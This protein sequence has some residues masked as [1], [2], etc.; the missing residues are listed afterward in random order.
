MP[1]YTGRTRAKPRRPNRRRRPSR[2]R[3]P[4]WFARNGRRL[5]WAITLFTIAALGYACWALTWPELTIRTIEVEGAHR[6]SRSEICQASGVSVGE[7]L[8]AVSTRRVR[9]LV[10]ELPQVESA[11][12][13]RRLPGTLC[14]H[15]SERMPRLVLID[16]GGRWYVDEKGV[17]YDRVGV[18]NGDSAEGLPTVFLNSDVRE[19]KAVQAALLCLRVGRQ[20]DPY[21][22]SEVDFPPD[23]SMV[24]ILDSGLRIEM[25]TP[26]LVYQKLCLAGRVL[27]ANRDL[28]RWGEYVNVASLPD[29]VFRLRAGAR[30]PK[31]RPDNSQQGG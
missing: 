19:K 20:F 6:L 29:P 5:V 18:K 21:V 17:R 26:D 30:S 1:R 16:A 9:R 14:I 31:A 25:G 3:R 7:H 8:F 13:S 12:V 15:V 27:D 10:A 22:V 11:N 23:G 4:N 28:Y 24:I 2:R